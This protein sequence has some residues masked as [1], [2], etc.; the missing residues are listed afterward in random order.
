M[1][2]I[3][4][5]QIQK[6]RGALQRPALGASLKI[7][8]QHLYENQ[9]KDPYRLSLQQKSETPPH[10]TIQSSSLSHCSISAP[11][12]PIQRSFPSSARVWR[13]SFHSISPGHRRGARHSEA[14]PLLSLT[15]RRMCAGDINLRQTWSRPLDP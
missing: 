14:N 6:L 2:Y 1:S 3:L 13:E 11:P 8:V 12:P 9:P 5:K 7:Y 10:S 4:N 15:E